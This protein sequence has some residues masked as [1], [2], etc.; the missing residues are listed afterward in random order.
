MALIAISGRL[1]KD[2]SPIQTKSDKPMTAAFFIGQ[3][4]NR[5][6]DEVTLPLNL[7]AFNHQAK[8]L[9]RLEKGNFLTVSG[10]LQGQVYNGEVRY[11]IVVDSIVAA[12]VAQPRGGKQKTWSDQ[13]AGADK[14]YNGE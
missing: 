8:D 1:G 3:V 9:M 6:E 13:K 7:V 12:K 4:D 14:L 2:P 5:G 11:S 10:R